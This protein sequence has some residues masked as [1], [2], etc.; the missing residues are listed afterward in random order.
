MAVIMKGLDFERTLRRIS[1]EIIE[2]HIDLNNVVLMGIKTRGEYLA[3]R[4]AQN[5]WDFE[6]I[7]VP[8]ISLDISLYRDDL[9]YIDH[10]QEPI[11]QKEPLSEDLTDKVVIIVDDVLYT[12]RTVR[13]ALDAILSQTRPQKIQLAIL[14][15]RGHRE[16]P[17]RA[18]YVGKNIP[19]SKKEKV[20]VQVSEVDTMDQVTITE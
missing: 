6:Q 20:H 15:D 10:Y 5:L 8:C 9:S 12:G 11:V 17:I 2:S 1:H 19:T 4:I 16:L 7:V 14:V 13:A 3:K 18:D